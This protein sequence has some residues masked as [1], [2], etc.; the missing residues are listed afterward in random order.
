MF[1]V[2]LREQ[3]AENAYTSYRVYKVIVVLKV[4]NKILRIRLA[5]HPAGKKSLV[6]IKFLS[7]MRVA[8]T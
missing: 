6:L 8:S 1:V 3:F 4:Y 2:P 5:G 7:S